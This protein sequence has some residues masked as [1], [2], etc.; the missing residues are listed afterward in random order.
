MI[1]R[2]WKFF[3]SIKLTVVLLISLAATSIV[4]TLIPQNENPAAYIQA[5]GEFAF[6]L[7]SLLGLFDMYHSWWFQTLILLL[8]ANIVVCSIDRFIVRRELGRFCNCSA[9]SSATS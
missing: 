4:G 5:F 7:F 2:I 9:M 1:N 3:T 8:T 6:Q